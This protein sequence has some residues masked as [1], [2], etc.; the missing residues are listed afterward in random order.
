[1]N[2]AAPEVTTAYERLLNGSPSD[3]MPN[4]V[5][6]VIRVQH[7][8]LRK[9]RQLTGSNLLNLRES[10]LRSAMPLE[11]GECLVI[12]YAAPDTR[13]EKTLA[14]FEALIKATVPTITIL[15]V[16]VD[17]DSDAQSVDFT[18]LQASYLYRTNHAREDAHRVWIHVGYNPIREITEELAGFASYVVQPTQD[19]RALLAAIFAIGQENFW[20]KNSLINF[21]ERAFLR[22]IPLDL[23]PS[24]IS[25]KRSYY[26]SLPVAVFSV[27]GMKT[28]GEWQKTFQQ[29][30]KGVEHFPHDYGYFLLPNVQKF[31]TEKLRNLAKKIDEFRKKYPVRTN[32]QVF[33]AH[34]FGTWLVVT[35]LTKNPA[36]VPHELIL[37]AAV[38]DGELRKHTRF[39]FRLERLVNL[40]ATADP[41]VG[42]LEWRVA[43][44]VG[45]NEF[46]VAGIRGFIGTDLQNTIKV[47]ELNRAG[48]ESLLEC[49]T[50][51][52]GTEMFLNV[53]TDTRDHSHY[54]TDENLGD[55]ARYVSRTYK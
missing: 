49:L 48:G 47:D 13:L 4:V 11:A 1:M 32:R 17:L 54:L 7:E 37:V 55:L 39:P 20:L 51:A 9:R 42:L 14:Q 21:A 31:R 53:K 28:R 3:D 19:A 18:D 8:L 35:H 38:V 33:L 23:Q 26:L 25:K 24:D 45:F 27:H 15:P 16:P 30:L 46:G 43:K 52:S 22:A 36:D 5:A 50:K 41:I 40:C 44:K 12:T 34:S 6:L 2:W 29:Q 10:C